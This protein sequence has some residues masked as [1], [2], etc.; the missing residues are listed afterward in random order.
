MDLLKHYAEGVLQLWLRGKYVTYWI[1]NTILYSILFHYGIFYLFCK[2][3]E[4][5]HSSKKYGCPSADLPLVAYV[6][7]D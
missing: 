7:M 6:K 2:G 4:Q 3:R 5:K 1:M